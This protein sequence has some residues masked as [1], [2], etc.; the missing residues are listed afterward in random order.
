M[1]TVHKVI[2]LIPRNLQDH[3]QSASKRAGYESVDEFIIFILRNIFN[4]EV[5]EIDLNEKKLIEAKLRDL[6]YI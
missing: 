3:L 1:E 4:E 5:Q 6:G 2:L